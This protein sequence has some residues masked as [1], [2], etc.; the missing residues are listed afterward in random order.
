MKYLFF[1][2][3]ILSFEINAQIVE[4]V[5][6]PNP[7]SNNGLVVHKNGDVYASDLFGTGFNGSK[8]YKIAPDGTSDLYVSGLSQPAGLV[9]STAGILYIAEFT[10]G[11]IS[12][13]DSEGLITVFAAGLNQ[14]A[15]LVFDSNEN[16]YVSNYGNGTISRITSDGTVNTFTTGISQPVG[17]SIDDEG[18]LYA[19]SLNQGKIYKIDSLGNKSLLT[20]IYDFPVG[21]MTYSN[22]H[23]YL[24]ST[25]GHKVYK[26]DLDG[27]SSVFA[28]NGIA[29]TTNGN[30]D[31]AQFTNPDG[32][33]ASPT[34]DTLYISENNTNLL[35]RISMVNT[36]ATEDSN[37]VLDQNN[38]IKITPNPINDIGTITYY[39]PRSG[40]VEM[41][42]IAFDGSLVKSVLKT[43]HNKGNY[44][45][46]LI[47]D[48]LQSG[49]YFCQIEGSGYSNKI[50]IIIS[51]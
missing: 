20:T 48:N 39:I 12:T 1:I 41:K 46:Q 7:K 23:L 13:V 6:G 42:L 50:Q 25:G 34:G 9:F 5:A 35:R 44:E 18:Y 2:T 21:F 19:A 26:I 31:L 27:N 24:C 22:E 15:D 16:L 29:G 28:G 45:F 43:F 33:A 4:T 17:L 37:T 14:P 10:S 11:E 8:V 51:H 49:I 32:I 3:L 30:T 36:T 47:T 40:L 38:W